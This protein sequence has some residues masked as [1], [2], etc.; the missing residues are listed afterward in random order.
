MGPI[1][2]KD[3]YDKMWTIFCKNNINKLVPR[4]I[5]IRLTVFP[6]VRERPRLVG[7]M[8]WGKEKIL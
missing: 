2:H 6:G 4:I 7:R 1:L 5:K 8:G 3:S